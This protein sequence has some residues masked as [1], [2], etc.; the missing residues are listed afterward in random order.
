MTET[1]I[2]LG[3]QPTWKEYRCGAPQAL[4]FGSLLLSFCILGEHKKLPFGGGKNDKKNQRFCLNHF[5]PL[6]N[7]IKSNVEI[8]SIIK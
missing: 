3:L 8:H 7:F 1:F 2:Y 6:H 4:Y 5:S